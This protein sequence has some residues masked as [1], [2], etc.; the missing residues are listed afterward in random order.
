MKEIKINQELLRQFAYDCFDAIIHDVKE[1][2]EQ[3][4]EQ[5][6]EADDNSCKCA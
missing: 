2:E 1:M 4:K 5:E 3:E 6:I